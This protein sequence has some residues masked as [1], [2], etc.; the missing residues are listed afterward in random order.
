MLNDL[1]MSYTT[2]TRGVFTD[3]KVYAGV[4]PECFNLGVGYY[5]QHTNKETL[6]YAHAEALL[7][8]VCTIDW[9]SLL[10]IRKPTA[11]IFPKAWDYPKEYSFQAKK[12]TKPV[13]P[14]IPQFPSLFSELATYDEEEL[15]VI[16]EQTPEDA[17]R[18][19]MRMTAK[20]AG[21][22]KELDTMYSMMGVQ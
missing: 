19:L 13:E 22:Q 8:A 17:A 15:L 21:L 5:Q 2:S 11:Q 18:M 6:D 7:N 1:G 10:T 14:V 3:T 12:K 20:V 16:C 4:I 9:K